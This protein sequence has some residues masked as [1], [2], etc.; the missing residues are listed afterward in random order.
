MLVSSSMMRIRGEFMSEGLFNSDPKSERR[1]TGLF[2][3]ALEESFWEKMK[4]GNTRK[5]LKTL[6]KTL[7]TEIER[8]GKS[9]DDVAYQTGIARSTMRSLLDGRSDPRF[10][11]LERIVHDLG[12][13]GLGAFLEQT[14]FERSRR[15]LKSPVNRRQE[16]LK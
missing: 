13:P 10:L 3:E 5:L 8:Q 7:R 2:G 6:G 4:S 16:K 14:E 12:Y 11:T 15:D 9:P 1:K